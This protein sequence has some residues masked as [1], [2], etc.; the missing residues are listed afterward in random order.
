MRGE[1]M[2]RKRLTLRQI[3]AA[4]A[5]GLF[6]VI[7]ISAQ[8]DQ[9]FAHA[10]RE[11]AL[12]LRKYEWK[13]RTEIR[14]DGET[15]RIQLELMRYDLNGNVQKTPISSTPEPELPKFGL[16][17]AIA[18]KKMGEFKDKLEELS[19]LARSYSELA[20][21]TMQ[22]FLATATV[23]PEITAQQKLVRVEGRDVLQRGD[24]LTLWI[25]A[26]S[27]KQRRVEIQTSLDGKPVRIVSEFQDLPQHGPTYM[28]RSNV[29]YDGADVVIVTENFDVRVQS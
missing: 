5:T 25:D 21:D 17:K 3:A 15:K 10:Q 28:A 14:K 2:S 22:R 8:V 26:I 6:A 11:N 24:S 9:R 18:K 7:A 16:R 29:N 19:A 4:A 20:P 23:T 27:H 12:A 13:A 1:E